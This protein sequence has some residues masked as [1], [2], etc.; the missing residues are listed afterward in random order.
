[1]HFDYLTNDVYLCVCRWTSMACG[2]PHMCYVVLL[3]LVTLK[4]AIRGLDTSRIIA[5]SQSLISSSQLHKCPFT[6]DY[7]LKELNMRKS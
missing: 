2:Y 5:D 1:M 3:S 6:E 4:L 7:S